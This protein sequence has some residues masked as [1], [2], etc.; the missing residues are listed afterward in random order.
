MQ[1][2]TKISLQTDLLEVAEHHLIISQLLGDDSKESKHS[3]TSVLKL[4]GLNDFLL[5]GVRRIPAKRVESKITGLDIITKTGSAL[6]VL[7]YRTRLP[8]FLD[9]VSLDPSADK[10]EK[11]A[12]LRELNSRLLVLH[13]RGEKCAKSP[14][15][16]RG[17]SGGYQR[18]EY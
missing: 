7:G 2:N 18:P 5:L 17:Q 4:L 16:L 1:V 15:H 3:K 14:S 10:D 11:L 6:Q 9:A 12:E 13:L 8:V